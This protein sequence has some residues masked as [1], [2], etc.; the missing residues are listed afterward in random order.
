MA[1]ESLQ[2]TRIT[3]RTSREAGLRKDRAV[4]SPVNVSS[5]NDL[6]LHK[7]IRYLK[8]GKASMVS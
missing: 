4:Q 1:S 5:G 3:A 6:D 2:T 8:S 7:E